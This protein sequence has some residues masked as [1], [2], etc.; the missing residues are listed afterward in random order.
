MSYLE[1]F[2]NMG[3]NQGFWFWG[4][5]EDTGQI[6]TVRVK[7]YVGLKGFVTD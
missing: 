7:C 1:M 2:K 6:M 4:A 3:L 5:L